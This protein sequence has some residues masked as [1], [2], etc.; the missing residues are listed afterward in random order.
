MWVKVRSLNKG[1][2]TLLEKKLSSNTGNTCGAKNIMDIPVS[3]RQD[4]ILQLCLSIP[5]SGL[6]GKLS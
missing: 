6:M 1:L 4:A 5:T 2:W 3:L